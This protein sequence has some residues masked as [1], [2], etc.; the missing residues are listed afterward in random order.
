[1]NPKKIEGYTLDKRK[2][3]VRNNKIYIAHKEP[4]PYLLVKNYFDVL[5]FWL[6]K[7]IKV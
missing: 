6:C 3:Y 1:M 4:I 7:L 5:L 2:G